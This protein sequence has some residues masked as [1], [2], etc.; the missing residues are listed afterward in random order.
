MILER[1]FTIR[2]G[3]RTESAKV[4]SIQPFSGEV[5]IAVISKT[6]VGGAESA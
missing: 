2:S 3:N 1:L 5:K 4:L 6:I